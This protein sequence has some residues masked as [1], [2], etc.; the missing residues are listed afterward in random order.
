MLY[1]QTY[2]VK[3]IF[4]NS[5]FD[6]KFAEWNVFDFEGFENTAWNIG[7]SYSVK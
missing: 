2:W 3:Q 5:V 1:P 4:L 7:H 6:V